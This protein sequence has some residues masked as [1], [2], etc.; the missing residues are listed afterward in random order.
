MVHVARYRFVFLRKKI[1][2]DMP[3]SYS[4]SP[5][6]KLQFTQKLL[7]CKQSNM[8]RRKL[9]LYHGQLYRKYGEG[10]HSFFPYTIKFIITLLFSN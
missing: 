10:L 7:V 2:V 5:T 1:R 9:K 4:S 8:K 6:K 3:E